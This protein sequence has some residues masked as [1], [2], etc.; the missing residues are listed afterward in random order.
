LDC[1]LARHSVRSS[2]HSVCA[3]SGFLIGPLKAGTKLACT[4]HVVLPNWLADDLH[5]CGAGTIAL[6]LGE[7]QALVSL[8]PKTNPNGIERLYGLLLLA[9]ASA[10]S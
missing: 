2:N 6:S 8:H 4:A 1:W 5:S 9:S 10:F 3:G 7:Q